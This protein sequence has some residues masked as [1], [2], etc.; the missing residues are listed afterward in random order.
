LTD[1]LIQGFVNF[2]TADRGRRNR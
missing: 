1:G 2:S